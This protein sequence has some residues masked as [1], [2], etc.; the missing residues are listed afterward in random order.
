MADLKVIKLVN[1]DEVIGYVDDGAVKDT[2]DEGEEYTVRNL[3]FIKGPMR[4][5]QEYDRKSRGHSIFLIDWM[6][7]CNSNTLPIPKDKI[8]TMDTPNES[9]IEHYAELMVGRLDEED[10]EEE[11]NKV[12][13]KK[14][15]TLEILKNLK[16]DD[17]MH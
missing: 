7:S 14:Q 2:N 9:V 3:I 16:T 1:G 15:A 13:L 11:L 12:E 8:I 5:V 17:D 10:R 6:P 4:V